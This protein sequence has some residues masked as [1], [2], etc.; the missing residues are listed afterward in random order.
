MRGVQR[1]GGREGVGGVVPVSERSERRNFFWAK[2]SY[3]WSRRRARGGRSVEHGA[4]SVDY[5]GV[6]R[7]EVTPH[8]R[9][10]VGVTQ[11]LLNV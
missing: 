8:G 11:Y 4:R 6:H 7:V 10:R 2:G 5:A 9:S 3:R 1:Q